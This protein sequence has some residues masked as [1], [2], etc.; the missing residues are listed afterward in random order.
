MLTILSP[1]K[2]QDFSLLTNNIK[3]TVPEFSNDAEEL[4]SI[5]K[6]LSTEEI[7]IL[8]SLSA[9]L[10]SS[11]YDKFQQFNSAAQASKPAILAYTGDVYNAMNPDKYTPEDFKFANSHLRI[12][13]GLYGLLKPLDLI[14]PYRLEMAIRI[15]N[16][17]GKDLY[18]FWQDKITLC[19]NRELAQM[20]SPI[21]VNLSSEEYAS[22]INYKKLEGNFISI[23]F[24][25]NKN[26]KLQTI[27]LLAKKAR[28][29]MAD[30][31]ITN[32][33]DTPEQLKKFCV[34]GYIYRPELSN[35]K[36]LVF[37]R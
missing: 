13:S 9:K 34:N 36:E 33:I 12:I 10:S 21:L 29:M 25:E 26:G 27:G 30:F 8:M 6:K 5:C 17:K 37:V 11:T 24:K 15:E 28:G 35:D 14:Q 3:S 18:H 23:S 32:R 22:V 31:I 20:R 1:S 2:T 19:I 16:P 7:A 4:V